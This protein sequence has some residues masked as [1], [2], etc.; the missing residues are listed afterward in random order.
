[1]FLIKQ[2]RNFK[3]RKSSKIRV[4]PFEKVNKIDK[5]LAKLRKRGAGREGGGGGAEINIVRNKK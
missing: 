4:Q 5:A 2:E 1:M 3:I